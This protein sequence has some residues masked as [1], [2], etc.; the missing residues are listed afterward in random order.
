MLV[1]S[2]MKESY[3]PKSLFIILHFKCEST[4]FA[5]NFTNFDGIVSEPVSFL[6]LVSAIFYQI[7][8]FSSMASLGFT[9]PPLISLVGP[10]AI[11]DPYINICVGLTNTCIALKQFNLLPPNTL[12]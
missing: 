12:L 1:L 11:S 10:L 3:F 6:R 5:D 9:G 2:H 7:C 4:M 8:I